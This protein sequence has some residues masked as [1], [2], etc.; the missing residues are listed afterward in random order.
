[1]KDYEV[2]TW[3]GRHL[4]PLSRRNFTR[5]RKSK[6]PTVPIYRVEKVT[7]IGRRRGFYACTTQAEVPI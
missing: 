5:K 4:T 1:L 3:I 7:Q 2:R 6:N